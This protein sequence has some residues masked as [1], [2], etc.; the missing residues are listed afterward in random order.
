MS[1]EMIDSASEAPTLET[2]ITLGEEGP[3]SQGGSSFCQ[4]GT[5]GA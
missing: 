3:T 4:A 1:E 2:E 5:V